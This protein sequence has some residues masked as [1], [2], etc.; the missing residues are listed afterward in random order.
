MVHLPLPCIYNPT[1]TMCPHLTRQHLAAS[2]TVAEL[3]LLG[4]GALSWW[5]CSCKS[6]AHGRGRVFSYNTAVHG[7]GEGAAAQWWRIGMAGLHLQEGG[8]WT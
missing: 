6:V 5:D 1:M 2:P 7:V 8:T 4:G 3:K